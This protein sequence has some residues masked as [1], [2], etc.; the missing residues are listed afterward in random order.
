MKK[1]IVTLSLILG[2]A[3]FVQPTAV[4]AYN[5]GDFRSETLAGKAWGALNGGDIEAV[6]AYTNKVL[7]LYGDQAKEMQESLTSYPQGS[8]DDVFA[9]WA[10]NDV[11][12]SLFI[13]GEAYRQADMGDEAKVAYDS[14]IKDYEYGQAWD[15]KGWFWKPAEAAAAKLVLLESGSN[16]DFGNYSSSFLA[17]QAW[18]ALNKSDVD[19]VTAYT[20][21]AIE[22]FGKQAVDMQNSLTEYPWESN[23][24]I[25]SYW[26]LN[27][28]GTLLYVKGEVLKKDG[29]KD[30]AHAV[31]K[32]LVDDYYYAQCWDPQGWFW[33]PAEAAQQA[34]ND[35]E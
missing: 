19:A 11:A 28:I 29:K 15:S 24:K 33:K 5:F 32:T 27:D 30:E 14:L 2:L 34:L 35:L 13:Q 20:D 12:T 7:E 9:Y 6:L 21:K 22:L 10:L 1:I 16:I 23:D 4:E 17:G 31:Y 18:K 8:N 3:T 25:H 26:A